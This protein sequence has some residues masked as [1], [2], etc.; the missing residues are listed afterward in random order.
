MLHLFG[1]IYYETGH[2]VISLWVIPSHSILILH[3]ELEKIQPNRCLLWMRAAC[4]VL[5]LELL[6]RLG[7]RQR[8]RDRDRNVIK[9]D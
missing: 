7:E 1:Y 2:F 4:D 6:C 5:R 9:L 3:R 8:R